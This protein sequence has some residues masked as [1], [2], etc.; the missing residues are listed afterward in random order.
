V[1]KIQRFPVGGADLPNRI[2]IPFGCGKLLLF[3][4]PLPAQSEL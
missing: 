3:S 4:K 2:L 1:K